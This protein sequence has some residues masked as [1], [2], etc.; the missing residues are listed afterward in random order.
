MINLPVTHLKGS[1][2]AKHN[3]RTGLSVISR[4]W[5]HVSCLRCVKSAPCRYQ[6][7]DWRESC[8]DGQGS[9]KSTASL[10]HTFI[11]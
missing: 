8:G 9:K 6:C 7:Q 1:K 3:C 11:P 5:V 2:N 4:K 10:V